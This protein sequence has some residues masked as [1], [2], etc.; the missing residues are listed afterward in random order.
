MQET[1]IRGKSWNKRREL[2]Q[3]ILEGAWRGRDLGGLQVAR[4]GEEGSPAVKGMS[5]RGGRKVEDDG[6]GG[7]RREDRGGVNWKMGWRRG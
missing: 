6:T 4:W 3:S 1:L 5:V 2:G 7:G